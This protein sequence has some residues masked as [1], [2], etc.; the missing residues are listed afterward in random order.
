MHEPIGIRSVLRR[1]YAA[2]FWMK[3]AVLLGMTA[4]NIVYFIAHP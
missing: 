3:A 2:P 1:I 4:V